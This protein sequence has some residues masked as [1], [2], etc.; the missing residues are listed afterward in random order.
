MHSS[1]SDLKCIHP[2]V[3]LNAYIA[4][5]PLGINAAGCLVF[6]PENINVITNS[7]HGGKV[8]LKLLLLRSRCLNCIRLPY[9]CVQKES[10]EK[11]LKEQ[12]AASAED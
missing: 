12:P 2:S 3:I 1:F 4:V 11:L 5:L 9:R 8:H 10:N 7:N 6:F